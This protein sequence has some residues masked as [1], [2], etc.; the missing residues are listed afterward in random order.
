M[1]TNGTLDDG[2]AEF[3]FTSHWSV[4]ATGDA[5]WSVLSDASAWPG[6]WPGI[7]DAVVI[8]S[9]AADGLGRRTALSVGSPVGY[10]LRFGVELTEVDRG[11]FAAARVVGDLRGRGSWS[12]TERAGS[13]HMQIVWAVSSDRWLVRALSPV[14]GW[15]HGRVMADGERSL[16]QVVRRSAATG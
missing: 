13:T 14:A 3:T 8:R 10:T 7:R 1:R 6:W 12:L 16:R 15:A 5:V 11:R 2:A 9:G 4:P